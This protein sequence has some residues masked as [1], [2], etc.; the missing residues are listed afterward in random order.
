MTAQV[1][2]VTDGDNRQIHMKNLKQ[3]DWQWAILDFTK[4]A[5]RNDGKSTPFASGHK[6]DD[7]F[8]FVRP[9]RDAEVQA[10]CG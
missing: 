3:G 1:F 9:E 8:F 5:R 6:V 7:I 4:E 2:D 10:I